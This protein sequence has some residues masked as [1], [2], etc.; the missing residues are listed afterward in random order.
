MHPI[1][2]RLRQSPQQA[3]TES[4]TPDEYAM[5][6]KKFSIYQ[7]KRNLLAHLGDLVTAP[8]SKLCLSYLQ[9][10]RRTIVLSSDLLIDSE[11]LQ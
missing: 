6:E 10:Q 3:R 4:L 8:A 5:S 9:G 1:N 2:T 11:V 7:M